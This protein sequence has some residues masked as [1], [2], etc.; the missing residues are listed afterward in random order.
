MKMP[1]ILKAVRL[2]LIDGCAF[3]ANRTSQILKPVRR[4]LTWT[5]AGAIFFILIMVLSAMGA[6]GDFFSAPNG[7]EKDATHA[8][9]F[10]TTDVYKVNDKDYY[11]KLGSEGIPWHFR[12]NPLAAAN[13]TTSYEANSA[14]NIVRLGLW[15]SK[16]WLNVTGVTLLI[17]PG[18]EAGTV[19]SATEVAQALGAQRWTPEVAF[20]E[21]S[22]KRSDVAVLSRED[23][24]SQ[25]AE[26][27]T[28]YFD[29][30]ATATGVRR[31]GKMIIIEGTD[32]DGLDLAAVRVKLGL[33]GLI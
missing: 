30:N 20:T 12:A 28:F 13:V 23:A 8:G 3:V 9:R 27:L 19:V 5:R 15:E 14:I 17:N 25:S 22:E 18:E 33:L 21:K 7:G 29:P 16:A 6:V 31:I 26:T 4:K 11:M 24:T 32:S 10:G 2:K 1:Q